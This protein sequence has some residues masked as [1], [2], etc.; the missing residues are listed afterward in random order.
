MVVRPEAHGQTA[1]LVL[2]DPNDPR[3]TTTGLAAVRQAPDGRRAGV[4]E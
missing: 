2:F 3:V 4:R 1:G